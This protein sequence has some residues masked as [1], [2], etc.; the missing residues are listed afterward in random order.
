MARVTVERDGDTLMYVLLAANVKANGKEVGRLSRGDLASL[1]L[2]PGPTTL[3]VDA[4]GFSR[5]ASISF[6]AQ[7]NQEYIFWITPGGG[8]SGFSIFKRAERQ[9]DTPTARSQPPAPPASASPAS[10]PPAGI[11]AQESNRL[12]LDA[13]KAKCA[14]LGFKPATE[15]FG[16]CVLQLS[17]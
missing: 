7:P 9:F 1:D 15:G 12:S 11:R 5:T 14:E 6:Y 2:M 3:T 16:K 13:A 17:K 4:A 10:A 8:G